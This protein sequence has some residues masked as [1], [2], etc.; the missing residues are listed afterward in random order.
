MQ[1]AN[2]RWKV[3]TPAWWLR[4]ISSS[5]FSA[6]PLFALPPAPWIERLLGAAGPR[7]SSCRRLLRH[8]HLYPHRP[9]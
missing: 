9:R 3:S 8:L 7:P 1:A 5:A 6:L 4:S 2:A